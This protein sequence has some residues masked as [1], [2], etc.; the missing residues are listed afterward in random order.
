MRE[1]L[2]NV[3]LRLEMGKH[4]IIAGAITQVDNLH[5]TILL[6]ISELCLPHHTVPTT[7]NLLLQ[8][9]P[10]GLEHLVLG[11]K[12]ADGQLDHFGEVFGRQ[13][14]DRNRL[15]PIDGSMLGRIAGVILAQPIDLLMEASLSRW[16]WCDQAL[17]LVCFA[18]TACIVGFEGTFAFEVYIREVTISCSVNVTKQYSPNCLFLHHLHI[19]VACPGR[20]TNRSE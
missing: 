15:V 19:I 14:I 8:A 17:Y 11:V 3:D 5:G 6:G 12:S 1:P 4:S 10:L 20:V 9:I 7:T 16:P 18:I 13:S 2:H